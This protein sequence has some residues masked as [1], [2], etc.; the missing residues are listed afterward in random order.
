VDTV[1][2]QEM[3]RT[4]GTL[5][6]ECGGPTAVIKVSRQVAEV[7]ASGWRWDREW[8]MVEVT[9]ASTEQ[10]AW[11][12]KGS[13]E[14]RRINTTRLRWRL[15]L[16]GAELDAAGGGPYL[17]TVQPDTVRVQGTKGYD[18]QFP[19]ASIERRAKLAPYLRGQQPLV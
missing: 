14:H 3:L 13:V 8:T 1:T 5:L 12:E 16:V 9:A 15:R 7:V 11:R 19:T 2:Y 4:L 6:D 17:L 10:R 18:R